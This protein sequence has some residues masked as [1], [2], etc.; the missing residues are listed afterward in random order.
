MDHPLLSNEFSAYRKRMVQ[1]LQSA[2]SVR[3]G[4]NFLF[5]CGGNEENHLR[6]RF[7][8]FCAEQGIEYEIFYP[9]FAMPAYFA[10]PIDEPFDIADFEILLGDLSHAI[11]VFPEAPGSFAETGYFSAISLLSEKT[12]LVLDANRQQED[13]FISLGPAKKI[14]GCSVFQPAIQ[15]DYGD[16]KFEHVLQRVA[17]VGI[18]RTKKAL[19]IEGFSD[20]TSYELFCLVQ[21]VVDLMTVATIADV[22]YVLRALFRSRLSLPTV[23][24]IIAIMVGA[25]YLAWAGDYGHLTVTPNKVSLLDVKEGYREQESTLRLELAAAYQQRDQEFLSILELARNVD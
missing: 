15:L 7:N 3:R 17:R 1:L 24:K 18:G 8:R 21:R 9:E 2:Y 6:P 16:P 5:V 14:A 22:T 19:S 20:L 10:G 25:K 11:I 4:S 23:K 12:I 13:S